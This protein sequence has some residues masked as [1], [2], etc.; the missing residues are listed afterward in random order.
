[1]PQADEEP[2][3]V[4]DAAFGE[5]APQ[6]LGAYKV[7]AVFRDQD[8]YSVLGESPGAAKNGVWCS[9]VCTVQYQ[10]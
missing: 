5:A 8:Y 6:L 7:P 1:M 3:Y 10:W 9:L 4:F 2:L